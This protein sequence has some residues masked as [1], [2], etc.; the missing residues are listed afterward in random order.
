MSEIFQDL[1]YVEV[2]RFK[3]PTL[4]EIRD[5]CKARNNNVDPE[6]FLAHYESNGWMVGRTRMKNW[7]AAI[8]TWERQGGKYQEKPKTPRTREEWEKFGREKGV[9]PKRGETYPQYIARLKALES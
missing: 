1:G 9:L 7:K 8:I 3:K 2:K 6:A 5:H 4:E